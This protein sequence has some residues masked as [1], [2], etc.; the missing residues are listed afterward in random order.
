M[1]TKHT[2]FEVATR[3]A[4]MISVPGMKHAG[5][6]T[7]ALTE[8]VDVYPTLCEL[9]G[10]A[11]PQGLEGSSL[12]P[13]LDDPSRAW[14]TAAFSQYPRKGGQ[15]MGYSMRTDR[16]RYTE[17]VSTDGKRTV[18]ARE[19]YDHQTDPLETANLAGKQPQVVQQLGDQLARG[20]RGA[21][22]TR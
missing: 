3:A 1:W 16:Y 9:A 14:K 11:L 21:I 6:K 15:I 8:Y 13:Q 22:P 19:L 17:W 10:L 2:N 7:A 4:F 20:W 18:V 5:E 12:V